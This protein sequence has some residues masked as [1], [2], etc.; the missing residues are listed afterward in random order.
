ME[1]LRRVTR[2]PP[3]RGTPEPEREVA[4]RPPADPVEAWTPARKMVVGFGAWVVSSMLG[5]VAYRVL[6]DFGG[7]LFAWINLEVFSFLLWPVLSAWGIQHYSTTVP[8]DRGGTRLLDR[9]A[10]LHSTRYE[11]AR[12]GTRRGLRISLSFQVAGL[13]GQPL[14]VAVR[15]VSPR[16]HWLVSRLQRY[17][18]AAGELLLRHRTG[19]LRHDPAY[20]PDLWVFV[21]TRALPIE[22]GEARFAAVA[23]VVVAARGRVLFETDVP[24]EFEVTAADR[25]LPALES[26]PPGP[27]ADTGIEIVA[28]EGGVETIQCG[29]CGE[30]LGG[31]TTRCRVCTTPHHSDCWDFFGGCSVYA[32]EGRPRT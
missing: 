22:P 26:A 30:G 18:G 24:I 21:P 13:A 5:L 27:G 15:L 28:S 16:G 32:C 23:E 11:L 9:Q 12:L 7:A 4:V 2:P 1:D 14:E 19:P 17:R 8:S 20:F 6:R 29:V 10:L 31:P 25:P 3:P